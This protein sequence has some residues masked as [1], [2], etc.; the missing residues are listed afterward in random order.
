SSCAY[1]DVSVQRVRLPYLK[2][3]GCHAFSMTGCPIR[4]PADQFVC[5]DPRG[6]SQLV[7]SFFASGSLG[8]P[9]VPLVTFFRPLPLLPSSG[10]PPSA[11]SIAA[12]RTSSVLSYVFSSF[13]I[14][15]RT[16]Y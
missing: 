4:K 3:S 5:A 10:L 8:I 11:N 2:G 14:C 6:L 9:R 16:F 1:L 13:P 12:Q 15:Q 7:A